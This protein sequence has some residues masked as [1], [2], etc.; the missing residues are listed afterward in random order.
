M[1]NNPPSTS[2]SSRLYVNEGDLH[3]ML[4][5]LMQARSLTNNW[6]YPH[7]GEF[8]WNFFMILCHLDPREHIRLWH[9]PQSHLVAYAML[10]E[11]PAFD[12]QVLPEYEWTGIE[13]EAFEWAQTF[14][15]RLRLD[16]ASLWGGELVSGARQDNERRIR[17]LEELGFTYRGTFSE[18]NMLRS[19]S[20]LIPDLPIPIGH[21]VRELGLNEI[22]D[23]A[24]AER[25]VWLP[26]TVGNVSADDYARLMRLLG[27]HRELEIVTVTPDGVIASYVNGWIDPINRIGDFG[28]VGARQEFRRQ[29][30][31]RLALLE[32]LRRMKSFG[33]DRVCISTGV[34][35]TPASNLYESIGF[36]VVNQYLDYIKTG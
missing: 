27:Y 13:D 11:D 17:F 2:F 9:D 16:D 15:S 21:Q 33:M 1:P 25:D 28:P 7:V 34:T 29:G 32:G 4:D 20:E 5:L 8:L 12:W 23:R 30:L 22:S 35:N 14:L 24:A 10:G 36:T 31:T 26:W 3:D 6:Q 18:V 19:L